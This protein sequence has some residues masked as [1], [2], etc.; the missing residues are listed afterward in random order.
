[1]NTREELTRQAEKCLRQGR[2]DEAIALYQDLADL[3]PTDWGIVKQLAD[4]LE[5]AGQREAASAQFARW[6]DYLFAEGFHTKAAALYKKVLKLEP[7]HE[8]ALWQ[9]GEVSIALK[10]RADARVAFGRV[11][12]LRQRRNDSAGVDA[13]RRRIETLEGSVTAPAASPWMTP[14]PVAVV[15][16]PV[17]PAPPAAP[18]TGPAAAEPLP[19]QPVVL[20]D[21]PLPTAATHAAAVPVPAQTVPVEVASRP[22]PVLSPAERL[23][24]L[25]A[26]AMRAEVMLA[27]DARD[28]WQAVLDADPDD[29]A[30]RLRLVRRALERGDVADAARLSSPL[31][32]GDA[33]ALVVILEVAHADGRADSVAHVILERIRA[34]AGVADLTAPIEAVSRRNRDAARSACAAAAAAWQRDGQPGQASALLA[35]AAAI[36]VLDAALALQWVETCVDA[37]LPELPRAEAALIDV[38]LVSGRIAEART[39]AEGLF[40]RDGGA[41]AAATVLRRVLERDGVAD[42]DVACA[43][44]LAPPAAAIADTPTS[45]TPPTAQPRH[46]EPWADLD[47]D[48]PLPEPYVEPVAPAPV[49]EELAPPAVTGR[50]EFDWADLLGRDLGF[51]LG[52]PAAADATDAQSDAHAFDAYLHAVVPVEDVEARRVD[53]DADTGA[54]RP[55]ADE[56]PASV[57]LPLTVIDDEIPADDHGPAIVEEAPTAVA[58]EAPAAAIE[59]PPAEPV[60][61]VEPPVS[62]L[63]TIEAL[64]AQPLLDAA[65]QALPLM[66]TPRAWLSGTGEA[67]EDGTRPRGHDDPYDFEDAGPARWA[68]RRPL[69][70][71]PSVAVASVPEPVSAPVAEVQVE[72][73]AEVEAVP[74]RHAEAEPLV[75]LQPVEPA[76]GNGDS[77]G[78]AAVPEIEVVSDVR[79]ARGIVDEEIDLTLLLEQLKQWDPVLPE[80]LRRQAA[81]PAAEPEDTPREAVDDASAALE[82]IFAGLQH[83]ADGR[84]VAEQQLAAGRVFLAAGLIAEA[85]RAFERASCEPR[86]RF[87]ASQALAGVH[88]SR[89][90][91]P[92]AVRW[93]EQ[94]AA[95]PVPDAAVKR[96]VLYDLAESLEA[97]GESDRA[98][99]VLLD[100]LSQ[101]EDY[102]DARVR[103]DRLLRVDAGG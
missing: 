96:A 3:L 76:A 86:S 9:L 21:A 62:L 19:P 94:A 28:R 57:E 64:H 46:D 31:D 30:T 63:A 73:G 45:L 16:P 24:R 47:L 26:E 72:A 53:V 67:S 98:L 82:A 23:T 54:A 18:P 2:L 37:K 13:A 32:A 29:V 40:V 35:R 93:F 15:V 78:A 100:L 44:L 68:I 52:A 75:A 99:G 74:E 41:A 6:A 50:A 5:R 55:Q 80:P 102:R 87:E 10:L 60:V 36:G 42:V 34:G 79:D 43:A 20:D 22:E 95:A 101:V 77:S 4:L 39:F 49:V 48:E 33:V 71:P 89:G 97:L 85:A 66:S 70:P 88:H 12:E 103:L 27:P 91:L 59:P 56:P 81:P 14:A 38:F 58:P 90:Q 7:L 25:R 1:M 83:E 65:G 11:V 17:R 61:V 84:V 8:H 51:G 92:E 69:V